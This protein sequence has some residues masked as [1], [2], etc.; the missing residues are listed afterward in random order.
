MSK[1]FN[2]IGTNTD[3]LSVQLYF[4]ENNSIKW[5]IVFKDTNQM[6]GVDYLP[7]QIQTN[8]ISSSSNLSESQH[9][10]HVI[11]N[12]F[13]NI[14]IISPK[15]KYQFK[16]TDI[17]LELEDIEPIPHE[18]EYNSFDHLKFNKAIG[19]NL[20]KN[21]AWKH[22]LKS[23]KNSTQISIDLNSIELSQICS[24]IKIINTS[25]ELGLKECLIIMGDFST[26]TT[27][28]TWLK[29]NKDKF[30]ISKGKILLLWYTNSNTDQVLEKKIAPAN[31]F[32]QVKAFV[33]RSQLYSDFLKK[34]NEKKITWESCLWQL[35]EENQFESYQIVPQIFFS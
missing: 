3:P 4:D 24:L 33:I 21:I 28:I 19:Q 1:E 9:Q 35:I 5:K 20:E 32:T 14:F 23:M 26:N 11:T 29:K 15:Y 30:E 6:L 25:I 34:L 7:Q 31:N 27:N 10:D 18:V 17:Q 2:S 13:P 8:Q 12:L 16:Y 22:Y